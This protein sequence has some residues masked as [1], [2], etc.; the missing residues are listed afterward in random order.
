VFGFLWKILYV[1]LLPVTYC[2][3][4]LKI[5]RE[6]FRQLT[7]Q[8]VS[9]FGKL[10]PNVSRKLNENKLI[11]LNMLQQLKLKKINKN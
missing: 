8:S 11:K 1:S 9:N 6:V 7:S 4:C 2:Y 5:L 10:L 3:N